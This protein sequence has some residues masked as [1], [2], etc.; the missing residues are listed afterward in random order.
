MATNADFDTL[1]LMGQPSKKSRKRWC[2]G[3]LV[4]LK[5]SIQIVRAFQDSYPR[6]S[7]LREEGKL[8]SKHTVKLSFQLHVA[9]H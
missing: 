8:G 2:E 1:R 7:I 5:E 4:S 6:K 3:S 9:P